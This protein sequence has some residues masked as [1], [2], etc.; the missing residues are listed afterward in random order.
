MVI[1]ELGNMIY[2]TVKSSFIASITMP[3]Y[4]QVLLNVME[5]YGWWMDQYLL[6]ILVDW[7]Y[8]IAQLTSGVLYVLKDSHYP[9]QTLLV[10]NWAMLE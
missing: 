4:V 1:V 5:T 10:N 2:D 6:N 3:I 8:T 9:V 7:R